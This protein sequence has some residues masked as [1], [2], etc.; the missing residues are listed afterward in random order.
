MCLPRY[1][2]SLGR[3]R[4]TGE[5]TQNSLTITDQS[6]S[7]NSCQTSPRHEA[8]KQACLDA[9]TALV[10][11]VQ[12]I[13][14]VDSMIGK[15]PPACETYLNI[16]SY[17]EDE[18]KKERDLRILDAA[19]Y[20]VEVQLHSWTNVLNTPTAT[21]AKQTIAEALNTT[22]RSCPLREAEA[23]VCQASDKEDLQ[24]SVSSGRGAQSISRKSSTASNRPKTC[25]SSKPC[26]KRE[27]SV[28]WDPLLDEKPSAGSSSTDLGEI[29]VEALPA[30]GQPTTEP[31]P[32]DS[33]IAQALD[34]I[35]FE[36]WKLR[37]RC[38]ELLD[39]T[40]ALV[41]SYS[42][43]KE[44]RLLSESLKMK[45]L[46]QLDS[47]SIAPHEESNR[48]T[49]KALATDASEMLQQMDAFI[50]D[51]RN[52]TAPVQQFD[53][54]PSRPAPGRPP[55]QTP[56]KQT[57]PRSSSSTPST[58]PHN[59]CLGHKTL[60]F[61]PR[62]FHHG[63]LL[64]LYI[65]HPPFDLPRLLANFYILIPPASM[66]GDHI[67]ARL[68]HPDDTIE[69][70]EAY[71]DV[72]LAM[73]QSRMRRRSTRVR[74]GGCRMFVFVTRGQTAVRWSGREGMCL[75]TEGDGDLDIM[76]TLLKRE[77]EHTAR[78][79][80][81]WRVALAQRPWV[82]KTAMARV[83]NHR[84]AIVAPITTAL[85]TVDWGML[86]I[87]SMG[88]ASTEVGRRGRVMEYR[89]KRGLGWGI[90][91]EDDL[92]LVLT[93]SGLAMAGFVF[94]FRGCSVCRP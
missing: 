8:A 61:T 69:Q 73:G 82:W 46:E 81:T 86:N 12:K 21:L 78:M 28:T 79:I 40:S 23:R 54:K 72:E 87:R 4:L 62:D 10:D 18:T 15:L 1:L 3:F 29:Q 44:Y 56:P 13:E 59:P 2:R 76:R 91:I 5:N 80:Y 84:G 83:V 20:M 60:T 16:D 65:P 94:R 6:S 25:S 51:H 67:R 30:T 37:P 27:Q 77:A 66:P 35:Q 11:L 55:P 41:E 57:H 22:S 36:Y 26:L 70:L 63:C 47:L 17:V 9:R 58:P 50:V 68:L 32:P 71:F 38:L 85:G 49:R 45:V 7:A 42:H 53:V 39:P 14:E 33:A 93:L 31:S 34:T 90:R 88:D 64:T 92:L 24:K 43:E 52:T 19:A 75:T 48:R 89:C 74:E